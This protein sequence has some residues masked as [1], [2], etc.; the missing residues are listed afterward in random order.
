MTTSG[1]PKTQVPSPLPTRRGRIA[2]P[3]SLKADVTTA[4]IN[5]PGAVANIHK[6]MRDALDQCGWTERMRGEVRGRFEEEELYGSGTGAGTRPSGASI[7]EAEVL[8]A[9]LRSVRSGFGKD[10]GAAAEPDEKMGLKI[11]EE[12]ISKV[13]DV[14]RRE[15]EKC[16]VCVDGDEWVE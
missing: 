6:A 14:V 12:A 16:C 2:V 1:G 9:V 15:L 5:S 4:L 3:A 10:A 13:S 8:R 7:D 11:P